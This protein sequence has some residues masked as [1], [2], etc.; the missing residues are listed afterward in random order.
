MKSTDQ[1]PDTDGFFG[2][3]GGCY[4]PE[5]LMPAVQE[6]RQ[7]F[8]DA[9]ADG[10]FNRS[11][12]KVMREF[13]GRPTALT[14]AVRFAGAVVA[15]SIYEDFDADGDID[16]IMHFYTRETNLDEIY[17]DLL[18]NDLDLDG[19]LDS[20]QQAAL[21]TLRCE[22]NDGSTVEG[23]DELNLLLSGRKLREL[24]DQLFAE[25]LL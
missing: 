7:A 1:R 3:F 5:I 2:S 18:L 24:L 4:M 17:Q 12:E 25:E 23:S 19:I 13:S 16:L 15:K 14:T 22:T 11:L 6:L 8:E 20:T 9:R 21:I 10:E